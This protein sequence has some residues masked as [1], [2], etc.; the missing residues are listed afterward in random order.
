M[1]GLKAFFRKRREVIAKS[2]GITKVFAYGETVCFPISVSVIAILAAH[3]LLSLAI[4]LLEMCG[5][6]VEIPALPPWFTAVFVAAAIGYL[7]NY[8][9]IQML[10]YPVS[11]GDLGDDVEKVAMSARLPE[12]RL[13]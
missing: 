7:T 13:H 10:Y 4:P 1:F 9:A 3:A 8:I 12:E 11:A 5:V 2:K 6:G